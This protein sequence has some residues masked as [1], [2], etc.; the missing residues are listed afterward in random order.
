MYAPTLVNHAGSKALVLQ[1]DPNIA[2]IQSI[3]AIK[4]VY[5]Q[6]PV[7]NRGITE[8]IDLLYFLSLKASFSAF[9]ESTSLYYSFIP[10]RKRTCSLILFVW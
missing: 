8:L 1:T 3:T 4:E 2:L 7:I 5:E 9:A 6:D 10:L